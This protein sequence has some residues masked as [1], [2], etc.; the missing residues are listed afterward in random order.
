MTDTGGF[1]QAQLSGEVLFYSRPEPLSKE[2][3][4]SLGLKPTE[5]P[6]AFTAGAH[7]VPILV[8]EFA[9]AALCYPI[10]FMGQE[11]MPVAVLGVNANENLFVDAHGAYAPDC[12]L[13]AY[14][15]RYPFVL[16]NDAQAQRMILCIDRAAPMISATPDTPFFVD[17][18]LSE[19]TKN[20]VE[21]CNNFEGERVRTESFIKLL[22]DLDL[23]ETKTA[24]FTP[25]PV[26][27]VAQ[28]PQVVAEYL[29]VSEQKLNA[30]PQEKFIELRDNGALAQ[31]Y[32]HLV[33]LLGWDRLIV[34]AMLKPRA[35]IAANA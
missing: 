17:G 1:A 12:Y 6:Y 4:G 11:K 35:P 24:M 26:N 34:K 21:F 14:V 28:Q 16:A 32:A 7:V 10:I 31:I 5:H 25:P 9:P 3:H 8:T 22:T 20:A 15:R 13:P 19:Y 18:E 27:G 23:F 29:G 2:A 30:L 33:S